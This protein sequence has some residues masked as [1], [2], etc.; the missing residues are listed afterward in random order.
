MV[1]KTRRP[2]KTA[3]HMV[4]VFILHTLYK[5]LCHEHCTLLCKLQ[6]KKATDNE[7]LFKPAWSHFWIQKIRLGVV[8]KG[9]KAL[10]NYFK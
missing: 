2:K 6:D 10:T 3:Q 4:K 1:D 5:Q 8:T 9:E 7:L